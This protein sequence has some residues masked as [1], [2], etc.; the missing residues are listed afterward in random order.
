MR[1]CGGRD[2]WAR[3][4][5]DN[6]LLHADFSVTLPAEDFN[7]ADAFFGRAAQPVDEIPTR[8]VIKQTVLGHGTLNHGNSI[9]DLKE[10]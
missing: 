6:V 2:G 4:G 7:G 5:L 3:D 8:G 1:M 10:H 9:A